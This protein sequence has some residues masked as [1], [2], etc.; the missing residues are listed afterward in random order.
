MKIK[1]EENWLKI[2][3][4][5]NIIPDGRTVLIL[6]YNGSI[7]TANYAVK[8]GIVGL[9]KKRKLIYPKM[10]HEINLEDNILE[11]CP[12]CGKEIVIFAHGITL[13]NHCECPIYPCSVCSR[14]IAMIV[15]MIA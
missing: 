5:I 8:N 7:K 2:T 10:W 12:D 1:M 4:A 14:Q 11:L 13:C 3:D 6:M 9:F 15:S